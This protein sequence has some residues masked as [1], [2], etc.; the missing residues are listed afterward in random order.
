MARAWLALSGLGEMGDHVG[1]AERTQRLE[2]HQLRIARPDADADEFGRA[3]RP[4]LASALTAAAVMALPPMRPRTTRNGTPRGLAAS[5]S[6]DFG[7]ADEAD[8]NAEDRGRLRRAGVEHLEQAE[9]RRRRIADGDD[10]AGEPIAPQLE[11]GGRARG[12]ELF[13]ER[14]H[15]RIVQACRSPRCRAGSRARVTP[16]AT[17]SASH[18][19]GAPAASAPRA[20]GDQAGA[21]RDVPR[22]LDQ[23]A[24]MDHAHRDLGLARPRSATDRPRRG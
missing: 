14:R 19:I 8:R 9:Q 24:G 1:F 2:R 22:R 3:H 13:G 5:A 16:C 23:A 4:G 6:F 17:I 20:A 21:E 10:G 12:A 11:R 7:R 15:A 18:R